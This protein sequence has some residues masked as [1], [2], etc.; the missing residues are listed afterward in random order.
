MDMIYKC[1]K[2]NVEVTNVNVVVFGK[3]GITKGDLA[4]YYY[5]I[6]PV[7]IPYVK[8]RALTM[9][10]F[11]RGIEREGFYHKDAPDYFPSWIKR[12]EIEKQDG[13]A[14]QY[15]VA[16][17]QATLVY[18]AHQ[19]CISM[20]PMLSRIDKLDYPDT[21][22]FDLDPSGT[23]F[24]DVIQTAYDTKEILES[25]NLVPFVKTTGSRGLHVVVPLRRTVDF[26]TVREIA[27]S[28]ACEIVERNPQKRTLEV[29]KQ[30]RGSKVYIDIARN[31]FGQTAVAPYSVRARANA[32]V[33]TPLEWDE[34]H[35]SKLRS[36]TYTLKTIFKRLETVGD[37]WEDMY[38]HARSCTSLYKKL[39]NPG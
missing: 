17:N 28:I 3:S 24:I 4:D 26:D 1:G 30:K 11:V 31:A 20:H 9:R 13:G 33:A 15:V 32:P 14:V 16:Q 36:N 39:Y 38:R 37:P 2:Y 35:N 29:R 6:A 21:M 23:D 27:R 22:V 25:Y 12:A 19:Y 34:L 10:R 5:R 8:D 7:M 18:L